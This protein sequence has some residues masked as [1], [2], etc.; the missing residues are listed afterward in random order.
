M[1]WWRD[2]GQDTAHCLPVKRC[3]PQRFPNPPRMVKHHLCHHSLSVVSPGVTRTEHLRRGA[4]A[5]ACGEGTK[6]PSSWGHPQESPASLGPEWVSESHSVVSDSLWPRGI[7]HGIL[8]A[9]I[10]EWVAVP[11]SRGSS[12]PRDGTQVSHIAGGFFT[13]W[14]TREAQEYGSGEPVPSPGHLPNWGIELG[15]PTVQADSS[16]AEPPGQP[17]A[18]ESR[19]PLPWARSPSSVKRAG[20]ASGYGWSDPDLVG[21][22]VFSL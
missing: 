10:L 7:V 5:S 18:C 20:V 4:A 8:Q 21:L 19:I 17:G 22:T 11:F 9:R 12:Q 16:P 1:E 3:P 6:H 2:E 15:S 13:S 14:A